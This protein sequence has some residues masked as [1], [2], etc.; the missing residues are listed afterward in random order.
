MNQV[1]TSSC[2]YD[3]KILKKVNV[4]LAG[5][6]HKSEAALKDQKLKTDKLTAKLN[7]LNIRNVNKKLKRRD[8]KTFDNHCSMDKRS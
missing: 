1:M 7:Q 2:N 8:N 5:E 6:L 4:D 3:L